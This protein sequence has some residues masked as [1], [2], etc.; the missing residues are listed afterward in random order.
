MFWQ[1]VQNSKVSF[2]KL[3]CLLPFTRWS[4]SKLAV[5]RE[6][7]IY[8]PMSLCTEWTKICYITERDVCSKYRPCSDLC[9]NVAGGYRCSC[10]AGRVLNS[11]KRTCCKFVYL[12]I[13]EC[14][15]QQ[16]HVL[17]VLLIFSSTIVQYSRALVRCERMRLLTTF[18]QC[19]SVAWSSLFICNLCL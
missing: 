17:M 14:T 18:Q 15:E 3:C 2:V 1:T 5:R 4:C 8:L 19:Y 11:D 16:M 6:L 7:V 10:R 12:S 13:T 9:T